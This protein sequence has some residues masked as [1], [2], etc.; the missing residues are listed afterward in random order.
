VLTLEFADINAG[1][2]A[3]TGRSNGQDRITCVNFNVPASSFTVVDVPGDYTAVH[4]AGV[5][6]MSN[7]TSRRVEI[8]GCNSD[9]GTLT[10]GGSTETNVLG[11]VFGTLGCNNSGTYT[12]T[13]AFIRA[14]T[15][16]N[17]TCT[18]NSTGCRFAG[19]FA[20]AAGAT[21]IDNGSVLA[22]SNVTAVGA[23]GATLDSSYQRGTILCT[24]TNTITL[25]AA[26]K[27]G[28]RFTIKAQTGVIVTIGRNGNSI[29]G[30][31]ADY[32]IGAL[33]SVTLVGDGTNW[34]IIS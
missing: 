25:P 10:L 26:A 11:G 22:N 28:L 29:E 4:A 18:L 13:G 2:T 34:W 32:V 6:D 21:W 1:N 27:A 9:G 20:V 7:S 14:N 8:I 12:I 16:V 3:L 31:A 19:T 33:S 15:T 24:A 17:S 30:A 23:G 5:L